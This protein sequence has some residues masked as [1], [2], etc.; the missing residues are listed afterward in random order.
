MLIEFIPARHVLTILSVQPLR[1][2]CPY[3]PSLLPAVRVETV[4][5]LSTKEQM[6]ACQ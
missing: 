6:Q 2:P 5:K 3:F 1:N 4:W